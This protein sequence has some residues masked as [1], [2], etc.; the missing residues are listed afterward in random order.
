MIIKVFIRF[1][2]ILL[3]SISPIY[4]NIDDDIDNIRD[5]S[6]AE[7]FK[8]MNEFKKKIIKMKQKERIK[9]IQKLSKVNNKIDKGLL[10]EMKKNR[11]KNSYI[12][13]RIQDH[14]E[15]EAQNHIEDSQDDR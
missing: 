2:L 13:S 5:A 4:S 9:A 6:N 12:E 7:R 15:N 11:Q 3:L 10:K 14:I 1:L 8:L